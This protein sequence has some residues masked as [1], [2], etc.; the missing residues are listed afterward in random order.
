MVYRE[1]PQNPT[2][3]KNPRT[4]K[5]VFPSNRDIPYSTSYTESAGRLLCY[6]LT[7]IIP[8]PLTRCIS[9]ILL[10]IL[11]ANCR[12]KILIRFFYLGFSWNLKERS[13]M[14]SSWLHSC[15]HY[16]FIGRSS[17]DTGRRI[18]VRLHPWVGG[19][20]TPRLPPLFHALPARPPPAPGPT[21]L[22]HPVLIIARYFSVFWIRFGSGSGSG[23]ELS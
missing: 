22:R 17:G 15:M 6:L 14:L 4:N 10:L 2:V 5:A 16:S 8:R 9:H 1:N 21:P 19:A 13:V 3:G 7:T 23:C 20:E 18:P 11:S 12:R